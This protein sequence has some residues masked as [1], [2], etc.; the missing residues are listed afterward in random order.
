VVKTFNTITLQ[1]LTEVLTQ[2]LSET[3]SEWLNEAIK[4]IQSDSEAQDTQLLRS[5]MANRKLSSDILHDLPGIWTIAEAARVLLLQTHL[6]TIENND[7]RYNAIWQ[8]YRLGD[9]NEKMAYIKGLSLLDPGGELLDIALHTG[10][11]NNV[12]LFSAIALHNVYPARYYDDNA[13]E[14]LVLKTLF[15]DL[16]ASHIDA[17]QQRLHPGLSSRCMDLVRERLAADRQPPVSIWLGIDVRHLDDESQAQYLKYLS[18]PAKEHRYYSLLALKQL[19]LLDQH[20]DQIKQLQAIETE[21]AILQL[22]TDT[23]A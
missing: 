1:Q 4:N 13:F 20:Q 23:T 16:S 12:F 22:L 3:Q 18:D 5:A 11:T 8:A 7:G 10:R 21:P 6:D 14:Q 17:L 2:Q 15:L 19:G 9:E